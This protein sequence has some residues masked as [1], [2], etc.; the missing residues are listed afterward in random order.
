MEDK[1]L[2]NSISVFLEDA[3]LVTSFTVGKMRISET[4][5][6]VDPS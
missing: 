5:N 3:M 4:T 2:K 6:S 1:C